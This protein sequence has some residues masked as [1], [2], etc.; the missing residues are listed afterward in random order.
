MAT[1]IVRPARWVHSHSA[2]VRSRAGRRWNAADSRSV[3][4]QAGA[5]YAPAAEHVQVFEP[6][7]R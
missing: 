7:L 6:S 4:R 1:I 3:T 2:Q 5:R